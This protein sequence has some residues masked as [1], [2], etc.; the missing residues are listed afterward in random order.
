[1]MKSLLVVLFSASL[2]FT[3]AY[4]S[5][6]ASGN[7]SVAEDL[8]CPPL[9]APEGRIVQVVNEAELWDAV[10]EGIPGTTILIADGTYH[11]AQNGAYLWIDT[12]DV[13]LRSQ[14]GDREAVVL[15]D[16]YSGSEII[17]V[18]ASDVTIADL[19]IKRAG[20]H[21]IH[22]V[23]SDSGDTRGTLIYNVHIVD[24]GQQGIK[25]NPHAAQ[26]YFPDAGEIA[27]SR[28][29][30][31]AGGRAAVMDINGSCYTGGVDAH[32]ARDWII[33]DNEIE[34]FWCS[35][36]LS[37]HAIH[38][39]RGSRD[40]L[41]ER[42]ILRDNARGVGLGL[43]TSGQARTYPDNPC[44]AAG[45]GYVDHY[46]GL[47]RNNFV[48][49]S[50]PALFGSEY[51]FDCGICL[52]QACGAQVIHNTVAS[53]QPPFSSIEWRFDYTD[54]DIINNLV[55]HNLNDRGGASWLEG[56]LEGGA[57]SLFVDGPAGNLHLDSG[58]LAAIDM[59]VP[60]SGGLCDEDIDG[61]G[62]PAGSAPDIGADEA[63]TPRPDAVMDLRASRVVTSAG[64]L[65]A[66]LDWTAPTGA[67]TTTLRYADALITDASWASAALLIDSLPGVSDAY[68]ATLPYDG[69]TIFFALKSQNAAGEWSDLSNNAFWPEQHLW[70]PYIQK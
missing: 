24:P 56:N 48:F 51:G 49:A 27:C 42:N 66:Y 40:T 29:E 57:L 68:T 38:T 1:M 67:A 31:T 18:A 8:H 43:A 62:R 14:S 26:I 64:S 20:T 2:V 32:Q 47:V 22:V 54:V 52:W 55:T 17:T 30:L 5:L 4:A 45:G 9:D 60:V 25:I 59:G 16:A 36:G 33:R 21:P 23:S 46:G 39:W 65:V 13:T 70:L 41:V 12:P 35:S 63:V 3:I 69:G 44:P 34:G 53:T 10:N 11:L 58:A 15:D 37:E 28:I 50:N 6:D 19:T 61:D 7:S